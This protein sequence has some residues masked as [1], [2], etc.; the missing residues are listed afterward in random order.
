MH[1]FDILHIQSNLYFASGTSSQA[2]HSQICKRTPAHFV[3]VGGSTDADDF[4]PLHISVIHNFCEMMRATAE[5]HLDQPII[6][7]SE[8]CD[9]RSIRNACLLLGCYLILHLDLKPSFILDVASGRDMDE[10]VTDCWRALDLA[11]GHRWLGPSDSAYDVEVGAHYATEANGGIHVLVPGKLLL[12][13][14]PAELPADQPWADVSEAG[15]PAARRFSAAFLAELLADLDVS[16]VACLGQTTCS[17]EGFV[18]RGL[19][20]H[21]LGVDADRPALLGALDRLLALTAAAPGAVAVFVDA[22]ARGG[23]PPAL[24]G[25]LAVAYLMR[26][27]GFDAAAATA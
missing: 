20:V 12:F 18:E 17:A 25:T 10:A 6:V 4:L 1:A 23:A 5:T 13:P 19:D 2:K 16:V 26:G 8:T 3:E 14:T 22:D 9:A 11:R 15:R 24:V 7:C 27:C 21:D